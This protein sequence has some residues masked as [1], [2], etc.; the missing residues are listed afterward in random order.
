M[1][2]GQ[3]SKNDL[4]LK[5]SSYKDSKPLRFLETKGIRRGQKSVSCYEATKKHT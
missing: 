2:T 4:A 1:H 5:Q 3:Y